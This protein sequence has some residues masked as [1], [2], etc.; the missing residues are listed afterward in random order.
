MERADETGCAVRGIE[1]V[2]LFERV[3]VERD[4]RID[5]GAFLIV[6]LDAI[7]IELDELPRRER[8]GG[9]AA[10][11]LRDRRFHDVE[12]RLTHRA[13]RE[14]GEEHHRIVVLTAF[15]SDGT[16]AACYI[17]YNSPRAAAVPIE[18]HNPNIDCARG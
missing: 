2:C 7:E 13:G 18:A 6:C 14:N 17:D 10:M 8:A 3:G 4:D 12:R 16:A 1:P 9:V 15:A 5:A 11:D